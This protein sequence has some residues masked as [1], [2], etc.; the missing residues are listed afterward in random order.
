M[1]Q[2]DKV[3]IGEIAFGGREHLV[4]IAPAPGKNARGLMAYTLRYAEELRDAKTYFGNIHEHAIDKK[5]LALANELIRAHSAPFRLEDFKDD[6]EAALRDLI[7]AKRKDKPLPV[8]EEKPRPKVI[9]LMDALK[10]S[11]SESNQKEARPRA[12]SSSRSS[13]NGPTLVKS[14]KR[15][16]KA[17]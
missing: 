6:Y 7:E 3:A 4:A 15:S 5:Q 9:N 12:R 16:R 10:R 14:R 13:K 8:A 11:V 1:L 2:A 17:A